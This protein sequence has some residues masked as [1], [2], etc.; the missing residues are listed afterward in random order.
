MVATI[1][2]AAP[3]KLVYR[4]LNL[5]LE[6]ST[7]PIANMNSNNQVNPNLGFAYVALFK[8][9]DGANPSS[10]AALDV[11]SVSQI[12]TSLRSTP[13]LTFTDAGNYSFVLVNN[14]QG[15]TATTSIS[16]SI[17]LTLNVTGTARTVLESAST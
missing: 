10:L 13:E 9:Y 16:S 8:D 3:M 11:V 14:T 6:A 2:I 15:T 4:Y 17:D 5:T 12:T 1:K 7:V